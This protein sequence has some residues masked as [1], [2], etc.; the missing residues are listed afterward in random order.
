MSSRACHGRRGMRIIVSDFIS[1]DGG[2][3]AAGLSP[4]E[5]LCADGLAAA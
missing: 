4:G 1:L 5:L 2:V 3:R